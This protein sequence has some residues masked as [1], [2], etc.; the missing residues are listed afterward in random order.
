MPFRYSFNCEIK[1]VNVDELVSLP[2]S[3]PKLAGT[4]ETRIRYRS[5]C[6]PNLSGNITID[7]GYLNNVEFLRWFADFFNIPSLQK[8]DFNKLTISFLVDNNFVHLN[9]IDLD[10]KDV[11]LSGYFKLDNT[12]WGSG[13]LSLTLS[14]EL[15]EA[16]PNFQSLLRHLKLDPASL[17]FD[18]Q[19][20]GPLQA[21]NIKWLESDFKKELCRIIPDSIERDLDKKIEDALTSFPENTG[22]TDP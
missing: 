12:D 6:Q 13:K 9:K 2:P 19:F 5:H 16:S 17:S 4:L 15:L 11:T 10:S 22:L 3:L 20:S 18:F 1:E 14:K 7:N 21:M 8:L